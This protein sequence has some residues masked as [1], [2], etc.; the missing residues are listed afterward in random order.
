[1]LQNFYC[2]KKQKNYIC[3]H[4]WSKTTK[5][6]AGPSETFQ[7]NDPWHSLRVFRWDLKGTEISKSNYA[8][9]DF[10]MWLRGLKE[11]LLLVGR[12]ATYVEHA[13]GQRICTALNVGI[14]G[15]FWNYRFDH[16]QRLQCDLHY[17]MSEMQSQASICRENKRMSDGERGPAQEISTGWTIGEAQTVPAFLFK[18]SQCQWYEILCHWGCQGRCFHIRSTWKILDRQ[19][20]YHH[21]RIE[22]KQ[23]IARPLANS[24]NF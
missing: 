18:W 13:K 14:M 4:I 16:L 20:M 5:Y 8:E 19:A 17:W 2:I 10:M 15:N 11:T 9:Q 24:N 21:K 7:D 1:M 23:N 6:G 12:N 3:Y 22:L